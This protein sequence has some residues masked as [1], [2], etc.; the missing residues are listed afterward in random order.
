VFDSWAA[1]LSA[2]CNNTVKQLVSCLQEQP[3]SQPCHQEERMAAHPAG[4]AHQ[5]QRSSS[6]RGAGGRSQVQALGLPT[7]LLSVAV[8]KSTNALNAG[9]HQRRPMSNEQF[10]YH[11]VSSP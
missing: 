1:V 7:K 10:G 5:A 8:I 4:H 9:A 11:G 6:A 3:S 2:D